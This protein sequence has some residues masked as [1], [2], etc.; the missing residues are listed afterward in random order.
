MLGLQHLLPLGKL[1]PGVCAWI[2]ESL[3]LAEDV[4]IMVLCNR[5]ILDLD[6][7]T[8]LFLLAYPPTLHAI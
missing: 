8:W 7:R 3:C 6:G 2:R 4:A 1:S 5:N